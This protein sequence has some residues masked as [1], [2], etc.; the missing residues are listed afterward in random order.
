MNKIERYLENKMTDIC[1]SGR[2]SI[3]AECHLSVDFPGFEGHFVDRPVLPGVCCIQVVVF[4][5]KK[6]LDADVAL[7]EVVQAKFIAIVT[8]G[9]R[10]N[11][12]CKLK[13][14]GDNL[15]SLKAVVEKGGKPAAK[16]DLRVEAL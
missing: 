2:E 12:T 14:V 1:I 16:V 9:D 13:P 4:L 3:S 8:S 10:L 5:A 6:L 7:K 15:F 11:I